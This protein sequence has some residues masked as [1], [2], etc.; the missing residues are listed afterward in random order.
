MHG[1][2]CG[3]VATPVE[4]DPL[5][6]P[7]MLL[8][9]GASSDAGKTT[10]ACRVVERFAQRTRLVAAKVT[11]IRESRGPCPRGQGGCG[12]CTSLT[13]PYDVVEETPDDCKPG[14]D[15]GR[16]LAAGATR[17]LWMR[18][19]RSSLPEAAAALARALGPCVSVCESSSLRLAARPDLFLMMGSPE[20]PLKPSAAEVRGLVDRFVEPHARE[21]TLAELD[22]CAGR[23][24]IREPATLVVLTQGSGAGWFE[25]LA[26]RF[27]QVLITAHA[28]YP[29]DSFGHSVVANEWPH[30]G[31][32]AGLTSAM[33]ASRNDLAMV[34]CGEVPAPDGELAERLL[35][36][37]HGFDGAVLAGAER[38]EPT[39]AVLRRSVV[40]LARQALRQGERRIGPFMQQ[41]RINV[42]DASQGFRPTGTVAPGLPR[43]PMVADD[44]QRARS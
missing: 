34:V 39:M 26:P 20:K 31:A 23:W 4:C 14:K 28:S 36:A 40:P 17:A 19:L 21:R 25:S 43:R 8:I 41:C 5:P 11:V 6:I 13:Q 27:E 2:V 30:T 32:L 37:A 15:T 24:R 18:A 35:W 29:C 44:V 10:F 3:A 7:G 9:A 16:L 12:A 42:V 22:L 1:Q 33:H 38:Q